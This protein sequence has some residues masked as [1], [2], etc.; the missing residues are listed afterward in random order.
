MNGNVASLNRFRV[1]HLILLIGSNPLPNWVAARL[2]LKN[3][4]DA[5]NQHL[6]LWLLHSDGSRGEPNT[7]DVAQNIKVLLAR[8]LFP[9]I[10]TDDIPIQLEGI[11]SSDRKSIYNRLDEISKE[12]R[13]AQ[14]IGLNYTGGTK[15]MAV[16]V[17][18]YLE[19]KVRE[20]G[21]CLKGIPLQFSYLDPRQMKL[22]IDGPGESA[23]I[24]LLEDDDVRALVSIQLDALAALHGYQPPVKKKSRDWNSSPE[25]FALARAIGKVYAGADVPFKQWRKWLETKP[26]LPPDPD[27][28]DA[29]GDV[30][31]AMD[32]L[33]GGATLLPE[34]KALK[35]AEALIHL[36]EDP[37][38]AAEKKIAFTSCHHWFGGVWLEEYAYAS[39]LEAA[40]RYPAITDKGQNLEYHMFTN[41]VVS[42]YFEL[43]CAAIKGYQLFALSCCSSG[44]Q[45]WDKDE[46]PK[47]K[48]KSADDTQKEEGAKGRLKEHLLEVYI[49]AR[50][51]GGDEA[52][53][54]LLSFYPNREE[55]ALEV[56]RSWDVEGKIKVFTRSDFED[57]TYAFVNWFKGDKEAV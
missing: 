8:Q 18:R 23:E 24:P 48:Q 5:S 34:E 32:A 46:D 28:F 44:A 22:R 49:R 15:P 41:D 35:I 20:D 37:K 45:V 36:P 4:A 13:G 7:K 16:H 31:A 53:I 38:A 25:I 33:A 29:L 47:R 54:G 52:K 55:L 9:D 39:V 17:Y 6:K 26:T 12:W 43:D 30:I 19:T 2:L 57:L 14:S 21:S 42:D 3:S 51:L 56:R 40:K 1:H 50:Q 10:S 11:P 27:Q